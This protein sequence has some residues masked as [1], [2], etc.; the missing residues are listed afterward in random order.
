MILLWTIAAAGAVIAL[1][2]GNP[3]ALAMSI[4]ATLWALSLER[5]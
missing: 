1:Q 5:N 3:T 4:I 2:T